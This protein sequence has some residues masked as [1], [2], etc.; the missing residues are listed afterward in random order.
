M[1]Q[2]VKFIINK[3]F[4]NCKAHFL[5]VASEQVATPPRLLAL[6]NFRKLYE[7]YRI[8]NLVV[9]LSIYRPDMPRLRHTLPDI[10]V[11]T[12]CV[13]NWFPKKTYDGHGDVR[14]VT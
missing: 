12:L 14:D 2:E 3:D 8:V 4:L 13:F 5:V 6:S 9:V 7:S 1:S 11:N 10:E